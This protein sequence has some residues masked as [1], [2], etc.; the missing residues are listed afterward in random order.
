MLD[1]CHPSLVVAFHLLQISVIEFDRLCANDIKKYHQRSA[2]SQLDN[3]YFV[4]QVDFLLGLCL[5][6][7]FDRLEDRVPVSIGFT[8]ALNCR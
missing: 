7:G 1:D 5:G 3:L 6:L 2:A 4:N 8:S